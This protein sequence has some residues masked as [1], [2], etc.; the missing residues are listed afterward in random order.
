MADVT[1]ADALT[2]LAMAAGL[3]YV[4]TIGVGKKPVRRASIHPC[5]FAASVRV[6][7]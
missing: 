6:A 2:M 7:R 4:A 1:A 3:F 5:V